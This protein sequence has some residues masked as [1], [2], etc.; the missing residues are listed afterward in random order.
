MKSLRLLFFLAGMVLACTLQAQDYAFR[1]MLNKGDNYFHSSDNRHEKLIT[2]TKLLGEHKVTVA[3][4]GY[5]A[6]VHA[7]GATLELKESGE[8]KVAELESKINNGQ[9]S[10]LKK[11]TK[12]IMDN[13]A[14][15]NHHRLSATGAVTRSIVGMKVYMMG[16]SGYFG[17]EQIVDWEDVK[18]VDAYVVVLKDKFDDELVR[19]EVELSEI[20]FDFSDPKLKNEELVSVFIAPKGNT[21]KA[22]G[23]GLKPL[24]DNELMRVKSEFE[25]LTSAIDLETSLGHLVA[26]AFFEENRLFSDAI[27][28]YKK[29]IALSPEIEDYEKSYFNF[30]ERSGLVE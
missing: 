12:Y 5:V 27:T 4:G 17:K 22:E 25:T 24:K 14:D 2:G 19:K 3:E 23:Y 18:G 11:Y 30:L 20:M 28:H 15:E 6:L 16:Y 29:A 26:A 9:P 13:I 1:I 8:Y 21:A 10:L 7:S